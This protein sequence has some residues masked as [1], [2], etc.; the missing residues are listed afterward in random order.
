LDLN[1]RKKPIRCNIRSIALCGAGTGTLRK[2]DRKHLE[3]FGDVVLERMEISWTDRVRREK[4]LHAVIKDRDVVRRVNVG[5]AKW[6]GYV[7][8]RNCL[9]QHVAKGD[10]EDRMNL[11]RR[12]R[13]KCTQLQDG[14][15]ETIGR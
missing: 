13:R 14:L 11:T 12:R 9:L 10:I 1:L 6:I 3:M 15:K 5:K 8:C 2:V 4:V 7:L